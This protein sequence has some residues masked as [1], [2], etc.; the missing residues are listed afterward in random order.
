LPNVVSQDWA[1][2]YRIVV[3]P[4]PSP[5]TSPLSLCSLEVVCGRVS[6]VG[7]LTWLLSFLSLFWVNQA[8]LVT[9]LNV[10]PG[11]RRD[12]VALLISGLGRS[13]RSCLSFAFS[14]LPLWVA[15]RFG[16]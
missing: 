4:E 7:E 13:L 8:E 15:S 1:N 10:E 9:I 11:G 6:T 12:S 2:A 14:A 5:Q 3:W 16:S